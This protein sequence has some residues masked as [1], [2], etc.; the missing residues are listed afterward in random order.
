M[1]ARSIQDVA[2][3]VRGRRTDL[4]LSQGEL[5]QRVGVSRKWIYEFEAGK[6]TAEFGLVMRVLEELGLSLDINPTS[7]EPAG[8]RDLDRLLEDQ[9]RP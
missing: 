6:P 9:K 1:K 7:G 5:A 3:T 4:G 8:T 2:A